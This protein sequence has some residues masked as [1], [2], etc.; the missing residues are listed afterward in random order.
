MPFRKNQTGVGG[1]YFKKI[2]SVARLL[3]SGL[4]F[5]LLARCLFYSVEVAL[6]LLSLVF[7]NLFYLINFL[8]ILQ[9]VEAIKTKI[10][11]A[12]KIHVFAPV[13]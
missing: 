1:L 11:L 9:S 12:E 6:H 8:H 5:N 13:N 4:Y 2:R 3:I 10:G 7:T